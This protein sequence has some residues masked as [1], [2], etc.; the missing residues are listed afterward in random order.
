[1]NR[2]SLLCGCGA[3]TLGALAGCLGTISGESGLEYEV[4]S[5][6]ADFGIETEE[7]ARFYLIP[8]EET[9]SALDIS[10]DDTVEFLDRTDF[11][12]DV[13]IVVEES[14][15]SR[16]EIEVLDTRVDENGVL[17]VRTETTYGPYNNLITVA[18]YVR[19]SGLDG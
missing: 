16:P 1:M 18:S 4:L 6:G 11:N 7:T 12:S 8:D 13:V 3:V 15:S 9:A 5:P 17:Q 10:D 14:L 19:I 2:S